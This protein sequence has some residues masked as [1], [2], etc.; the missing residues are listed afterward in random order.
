MPAIS[1]E[2]L[3]PP[4]KL[5]RFG[6]GSILLIA[7]V[8]VLVLIVGF[9]I[10]ERLRGRA[11]WRAYATE[12]KARGV[13]LDFAEFIPPPVPDAENFASIPIFDAV[14]QASEAGQSIPNPFALPSPPSGQMPKFSD[15]IKQSPIDLAVWQKYFVEIGR[16]PATGDDAARDVLEALES[17]AAPLAQLREASARP[18]CRFPVHW[19][20]AHAASLPHFEILN[21]AGRLHALRISA[22][23]ALG[24]SAA[25]Y[26]DFRAGLRLVTA[27][28]KEP[29]LI[30]G[31]VRISIFASMT[32][33]I[34]NGLVDHRWAEPELRKIEADLSALDWLKDYLFSMASEHSA[35]N[36]IADILISD[37]RLLGEAAASDTRPGLLLFYPTGWHYQSKVRLNR[38]F[39]EL[40][41]RVDLDQRRFL[42]GPPVPSSPQHITTPAAKFYYLFFRVVAPVFEEAGGRFVQAAAMADHARIAC[43]LE[44]HWLA[45]RV[46]PETLEE[47]APGLISAVPVEVVNGEPYHYRRT[48]DG[49]F[50]LYSVGLDRRD[51]DGVLFPKLSASKQL[52]WVWRYPEQVS[53]PKPD[54]RPRPRSLG[55]GG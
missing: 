49:R 2:P 36:A 3:S 15:P 13:K 6:P 38:F 17:F 37:P 23:L 4:V 27:M 21:S 35:V 41:A 22:H 32:N 40:L 5:R 18:H 55:D 1:P 25:A 46:F 19:E 51:D 31:L 12:A 9:Y 43:A 24:D 10:E 47:L 7:V 34:W 53:P 14:F 48:E 33:A 26:E 28:A 39:D 45:H 42:G 52:D 20:R 8:G 16:L 30:A 44:R 29:S 54:D 11:A 50:L